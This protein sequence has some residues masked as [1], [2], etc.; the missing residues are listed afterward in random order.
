VREEGREVRGW[1]KSL[2]QKCKWVR[3]GGRVATEWLKQFAKEMYV[4]EVGRLLTGWLK[5]YPKERNLSD[6]GKVST[7]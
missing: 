5:E 1:V 2:P 7:G 6:C 3:E 4:S